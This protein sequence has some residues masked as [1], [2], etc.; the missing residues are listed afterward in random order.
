MY[1]PNI[2]GP[3]LVA[4]DPEVP[5]QGVLCGLYMETRNVGMQIRALLLLRTV[6][7]LAQPALGIFQGLNYQNAGWGYIVQNHRRIVRS[8]S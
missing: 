1:R 3:H 5:L 4:T 7:S 2:L 6:E 8:Q